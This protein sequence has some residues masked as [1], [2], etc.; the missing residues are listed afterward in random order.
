MTIR[1]NIFRNFIVT[2]SFADISC[3]RKTITR[4][5]FVEIQHR[6]VNL[7]TKYFRK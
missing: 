3:G 7:A 1:V 4:S 2:D 5:K 6:Q